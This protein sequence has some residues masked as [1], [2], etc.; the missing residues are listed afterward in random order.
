MKISVMTGV[1]QT[2]MD[3]GKYCLEE[4]L[5]TLVTAGVSGLEPMWECCKN[6]E[7]VWCKL[8]KAA[9][10]RQ[11]SCPCMDIAADLGSGE[12]SIN[13]E[14]LQNLRHAFVCCR[15]DL[16][17]PTALLY[18]SKPA[19]GLSLEEGR[20]NYGVMLGRCAEL[21]AE[22]GVTVCIEDFGGFPSFAASSTHCL[23]VLS[24][25]DNS[26]VRLN[27]DNG[28]FLLADEDPLEALE[29]FKSHLIHVHIKDFQRCCPDAAVQG[30]CSVDGVH[31]AACAL[32]DG[33][34]KVAPCIRRLHEI[35]YQGWL[36][37]EISAPSLSWIRQE[38]GYM[39]GILSGFVTAK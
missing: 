33:D 30:L 26:L 7:P 12:E 5:E 34:G 16:G 3:Q 27:F 19:P 2:G 4:L 18:G 32:G 25:A 20:K 14:I 15:D 28:N 29:N 37:A 24:H 23:E 22:Y 35:G 21:A 38:I 8:R 6:K 9:E 1:F 11:F 31:Y 39:A 36:S 10:R 17:C 13:K